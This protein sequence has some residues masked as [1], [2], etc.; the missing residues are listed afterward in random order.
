MT[1]NENSDHLPSVISPA[2]M[3]TI[4]SF[5]SF[6]AVFVGFNGLIVPAVIAALASV[7][8]GA[9]GAL[10]LNSR[11]IGIGMVV[12]P[13]VVT[14]LFAGFAVTHTGQPPYWVVLAL[15][16]VGAFSWLLPPAAHTRLR[17]QNRA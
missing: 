12:A 13:G 15:A 10:G 1:T 5:L 4:A 16:A 2:V 14:A 6:G 11:A 7:A 8:I 9:S 3:L 17:S